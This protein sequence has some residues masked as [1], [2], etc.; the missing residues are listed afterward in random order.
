M[1][2]TAKTVTTDKLSTLLRSKVDSDIQEYIKALAFA[3]AVNSKLFGMD[4]ADKRIA[5]SA[6]SVRCADY[7]SHILEWDT[8][9]ESLAD[10]EDQLET[11]LTVSEWDKKDL[12]VAQKIELRKKRKKEWKRIQKDEYK[13]RMQK[14]RAEY[15][16]LFRF[17]NNIMKDYFG[18]HEIKEGYLR[19]F[20]E[21]RY[22]VKE[23][24]S[25]SDSSKEK[26]VATRQEKVEI[27]KEKERK[28][29]LGFAIFILIKA[30]LSGR[31]IRPYTVGRDTWKWW[32]KNSKI[33]FADEYGKSEIPANI[34][35][36][37]FSKGLTNHP[38][39]KF[40]NEKLQSGDEEAVAAIK[41]L[42]SKLRKDVDMNANSIPYSQ[43]VELYDAAVILY[44]K[45]TNPP[46]FIF[47]EEP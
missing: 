38:L 45:M 26:R 40:I 22:L 30:K 11:L 10:A 46:G 44:R 37:Y 24:G 2:T 23:S 32:I 29:L 15:I 39:F 34:K 17:V 1:R 7:T 3:F 13:L 16:R 35:R 20:Y 12:A 9:T 21:C 27:E 18:K 8:G 41:A 36:R 4:F 19:D 43:A 31:C 6:R 28:R 47:L 14:W 5:N 33:E 42:P 25:Q